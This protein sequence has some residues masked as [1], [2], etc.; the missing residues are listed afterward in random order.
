MVAK[1]PRPITSALDLK[2]HCTGLSSFYPEL[3]FYIRFGRDLMLNEWNQG[4]ASFH[5]SNSKKEKNVGSSAG[6]S[7][8][9]NMG[10]LLAHPEQP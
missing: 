10:V 5:E 8:P 6:V 7:W 2:N 1:W 4:H 9:G 3:T